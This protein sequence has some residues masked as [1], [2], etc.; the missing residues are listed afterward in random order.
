MLQYLQYLQKMQWVVSRPADNY[1]MWQLKKKLRWSGV[2]HLLNRTGQWKYHKINYYEYLLVVGFGTISRAVACFQVS[3]LTISRW[4]PTL[5]SWASQ[6]TSRTSCCP[7][8][9]QPHL[10]CRWPQDS[11][12]RTVTNAWQEDG[13]GISKVIP[14]RHSHRSQ[15]VVVGASRLSNT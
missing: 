4:T 3:S 13:Y 2:M 9:R 6:R 5:L 8:P 1:P 14:S 7:T 11:H 15:E 12:C 10:S